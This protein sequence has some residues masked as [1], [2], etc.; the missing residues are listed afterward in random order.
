MS[1]NCSSATDK[2]LEAFTWGARGQFFWDGNK[3]TSLLLANKILVYSG[4][5]IMTITDKYMEQFNSL[6]LEYYNTGKSEE[7]KQFLYDNAILGLTI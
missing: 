5:G 3:R 6:L 2:A 7:L 1:D 4:A